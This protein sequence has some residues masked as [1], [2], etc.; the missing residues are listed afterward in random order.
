MCKHIRFINNAKKVHILKKSKLLI[1]IYIYMI[2]KIIETKDR[3]RD[4]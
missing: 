4:D 2:C 3:V 1:Y